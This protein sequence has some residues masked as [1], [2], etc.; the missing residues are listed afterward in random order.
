MQCVSKYLMAWNSIYLAEDIDSG[1]ENLSI[2]QKHYLNT[3]FPVCRSK[4]Y[5]NQSPIPLDLQTW[6]QLPSNKGVNKSTKYL[7]YDHLLRAEY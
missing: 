1:F 4:I 2:T 7:D 5:F 6:A 3:S